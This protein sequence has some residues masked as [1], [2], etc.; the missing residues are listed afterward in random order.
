MKTDIRKYFRRTVRMTL[1]MLAAVTIFPSCVTYYAVVPEVHPDGSMTRTVY[2]EAD[3]ACLAGDLSSQ[4]FLFEPGKQWQTGR[5]A[6]PK[7]WWFLDDSATMNFYASRTFRPSDTSYRDI[8]ASEEYAGLPYVKARER[9]D[10]KRGLL[11]NTY[12][13]TCT[14]PGIAD[15]MPV[16]PD[17][18]MTAEEINKWFRSAGSYAGMNGAEAYTGLTDLYD[19]YTGWVDICYREQIYRIICTTAGE[20]LT[21][22][23]KT[24]LMQWMKKHY[25]F[26]EDMLF[27]FDGSDGSVLTDI[28]GQMSRLS[29]NPVYAEA[30]SVHAVTWAEEIS[31][32]EEQLTAPFFYAMLYQVRM[33]GRLTS[34]NTDLMDDGI[35]V[36][37]VDG[38]RLLA[39]DL[40]VE[41][42]SRRANPLGFILLGLIVLAS[43]ILF[44][45]PH[46]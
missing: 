30:A 15:R 20:E 40:T 36:W 32:I 24:G 28:A 7:I 35:P 31:D 13:Y 17:S 11:F 27:A 10:R 4:P 44:F 19:K 33:P 6:E 12:S 23:L 3:S 8:P 9:W 42:T 14:V 41:A 1:T 43:A 26:Y 21:D 22:S 45:R 2:A 25:D 5:M 16:P 37:K 34:A 39:G 18:I 38:F 46:K 29:G